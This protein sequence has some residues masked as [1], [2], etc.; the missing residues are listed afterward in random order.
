MRRALAFALLALAACATAPAPRTAPAPATAARPAAVAAPGYRAKTP[1]GVDVVYDARRGV[2]A[3]EGQSDLF[4]VDQ[5][6][7]RREASGWQVA[8]TLDGPWAACPAGELPP[9]LRSEGGK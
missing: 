7:F 5:R 9:G 2:F 8:R 4:W 1:Q 3:V 6:Y